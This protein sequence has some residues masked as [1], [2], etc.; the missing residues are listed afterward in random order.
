MPSILCYPDYRSSHGEIA[1]RYFLWQGLTH[2]IR[3]LETNQTFA[4]FN[5]SWLTPGFKEAFV[6]AALEKR[7][8]ER[9]STDGIPLNAE[10]LEGISMNA[11][12]L[13][14]GINLRCKGETT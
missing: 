14:V 1:P 8:A 3:Y 2:L 13:G 10:M 7:I 6:P 5:K 11:S 4:Q 12:Q 9:N